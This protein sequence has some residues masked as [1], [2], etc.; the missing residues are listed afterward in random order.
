MLDDAVHGAYHNN[1]CTRIQRDEWRLDFVRRD[2][3]SDT[4]AVEHASDGDEGRHDKDLH[5]Q[6]SLHENV[7]H[8]LAFLGSI[9]GNEHGHSEGVEDFHHGRHKAEGCKRAAG[10]KRSEVGHIIQDAA[11]DVVI[12]QF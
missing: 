9:R 8:V 7:A 5:N 3:S 11:K 6:G 10:V 12:G 2:T 4:S 1:K